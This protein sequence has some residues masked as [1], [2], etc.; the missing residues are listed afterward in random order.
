MSTVREGRPRFT[1]VA[2]Y[3][4]PLGRFSFRYPS[5]WDEFE[6]ADDR[7]GVMYAPEEPEDPKTY[8]AAWVSE[9]EEQVVA[10]DFE[11]LKEGIGAGLA[12]LPHCEVE[13]AKDDLLSNLVKLE[14]VYSF[15]DAG[16]TRK[17]RVW[18]LYVDKW[19]IV[20]VFQGATVDEYAYWLP[21]GN[22]AFA[23]FD[24]PEALWYATD[25]DMRAFD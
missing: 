20:L 9:L 8:F 10:E 21:M 3:Q 14:R 5:D 22:Y 18:T 1:G 25:R 4:D 15:D 24:L 23:T 7:E 13:S 11:T 16:T 19:R 2:T 17:R 12:Q 6:L